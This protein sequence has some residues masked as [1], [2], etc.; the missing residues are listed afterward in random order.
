MDPCLSVVCPQLWEECVADAGA[1]CLSRFTALTWD[2]P[3]DAGPYGPTAPVPLRLRLTLRSNAPDAGFYPP[4][5]AFSVDGLDAGQLAQAQGGQPTQFGP[6]SFSV[7][8]LTSTSHQLTAGYAGLSA[9]KAFVVDLIPPVV[10]LRT[11]PAPT[12]VTNALIQEADPDPG[13]V[14]AYK[15]DERV[16]VVVEAT[17]PVAV[18]AADF[19][20]GGLVSALTPRG[21]CSMACPGAN[22]CVC[23]DLDLAKVPLASFRGTTPLRLSPRQD[24]V[25]NV[26][27]VIP[28]QLLKVTRFKW[29][30]L[31]STGAPL[32]DLQTPAID[33]RGRI[34]VGF[35]ETPQTG[36]INAFTSSGQTLAGFNAGLSNGA[37]TTGALVSGSDLYIA[38]R[39]A[40]AGALRRLSAV[41]GTPTGAVCSDPRTFSAPLALTDLKSVTPTLI[42]VSNGLIIGARLPTGGGANCSDNNFPSSTGEYSLVVTADA[43]WV[44]STDLDVV[45]RRPWASGGFGPL[46]NSSFGGYARGLAQ[47]GSTLVGGGG[48]SSGGGVFALQ[49]DGGLNAYA[50]LTQADPAYI[51]SPPAVAGTLTRPVVVFGNLQPNLNR[52]DYIPGDPGYFDAGATS[53]VPPTAGIVTSP[54]IGRGG[55]IFAVDTSG[56]VVAYDSTLQF[57]R[58]ALPAGTNGIAG[59]FVAVSPNLDVQRDSS[60][61]KVCG[62]GGVLYVASTGDGKLYAFAVDS[63]GVDVNAP[64]P[65]HQHDPANTGNAATSLLPWG[66]P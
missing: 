16:E 3:T 57:Q 24:A 18:A 27:A 61:S 25:G 1:L 19:N 14:D 62:R 30:R 13:Y 59:G 12:R 65:K 23:F 21:A 39:D 60:T 46:A 31:V 11:E 44:A 20:A 7:Q 33:G 37:V 34:F 64:W 63:D 4:S 29:K 8:G 43:V 17:E 56:G 10:T 15:K 5:L 6:A 28:D 2:Q 66:C 50:A 58:W 53:A 42:A 54:V 52:V 38:T 36:G 51:A 9:Q 49:S 55:D 22:V 41:T 26:S 35:S 47:F 48:D 40:T 45:R 32:M